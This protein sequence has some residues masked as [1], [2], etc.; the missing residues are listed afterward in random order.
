MCIRDRYITDDGFALGLAYFLKILG[1]NNKFDSLH[2][3]EEVH[4]KLSSERKEL[5]KNLEG[6]AKGKNSIEDLDMGNQISLRR[7][8]ML[9]TEFETFNYCFNGARILFREE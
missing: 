7:I 6:I 9:A 5:K 1:L 2:W 3:F 4:S 8:E